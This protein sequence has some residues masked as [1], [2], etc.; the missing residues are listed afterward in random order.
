MHQAIEDGVSKGGVGDRPMPLTERELGADHARA[1]LVA[2]IDDLEKF[3]GFGSGKRGQPEVIEDEKVG[4]GEPGKE[5]P[6]ASIHPG[7]GDVMK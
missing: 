7:Q 6:V 3:A 1:S 4:L 5:S 2:I